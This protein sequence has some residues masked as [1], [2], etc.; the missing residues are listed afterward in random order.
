M[1]APLRHVSEA[2]RRLAVAK[3]AMVGVV[4]VTGAVGAAEGV[5]FSRLARGR[6]SP[7]R[8]RR[9]CGG[10]C[11][12]VLGRANARL[13]A[14]GLASLAS[15]LALVGVNAA[16]AQQASAARPDAA[17]SFTGRLGGGAPGDTKEMALGDD[18]SLR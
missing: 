2:E 1:G 17:E 16:L 7:A 12:E 10:R 3:D 4:A 5:R 9:P 6:S 14:F 18:A 8:R 13:N 15:D 11:G